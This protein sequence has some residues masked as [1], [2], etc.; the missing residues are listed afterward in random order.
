MNTALFG[1]LFLFWV[2]L[3]VAGV[4]LGTWL[5]TRGK[6]P[7][8]R[9]QFLGRWYRLGSLGGHAWVRFEDPHGPITY[10]YY[11][12]DAPDF[13]NPPVHV[14]KSGVSRVEPADIL[15]SRRGQEEIRKSGKFISS[16]QEEDS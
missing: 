6:G 11:P 10:T 12:E 15:R 8:R 9:F 4:I 14:G 1:V 16:P 13:E 5:T 2:L 7:P 3:A